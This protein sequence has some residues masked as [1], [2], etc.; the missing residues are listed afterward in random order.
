MKLN[1]E[2]PLAIFDLETTGTN[3]TKDRIVEI[4]ILK[5]EPNGDENTFTKRVNPEMDIPKETS[6]IH[7]IYQADIENEKTFKELA[8]EVAEFIGNADLAG[9]NSNKFDIPVLMEEFLRAEYKF[10]MHDRRFVDVQ[11]IFH[12]MEQRTL[13]AA[14]KFY[15]DKDLTNA[16]SAEADVIA[17][18]EVLKAQVARY[19]NLENDIKFL[20]T[21]SKQ[22]NNEVVDFAGRIAKNK[23]GEIIYNFG[24]HK[25]KTVEFVA[26][27]E[28]GYYGW[29]LNSDFPLYTK[30]VLKEEM[31]R[32]KKNREEQKE[33]NKQKEEQRLNAKLD[34]LKNKFGK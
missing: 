4:S 29:F 17:T 26:N 28:P 8:P 21:F 20:S 34:A 3:V 1:L 24:K 25:N 18:Y 23:E 6:E 30:Q 2:R 16:H 33:I 27:T 10:D 13:V 12:K 22:G 5:V 9:F 11:N 15:C 31:E 19:E 14:Y 32:I 7:G